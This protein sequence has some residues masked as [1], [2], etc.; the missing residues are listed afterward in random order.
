M[1]RFLAMAPL[2]VAAFVTGCIQ[3]APEEVSQEPADQEIVRKPESAAFF[4]AVV[5]N[6]AEAYRQFLLSYPNGR[7]AGIVQDLLTRCMAAVC[8]NE[9]ELQV[10]LSNALAVSK[11]DQVPVAAVETPPARTEAVAGRPAASR[12]GLN[13]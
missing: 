2:A 10:A 4:D 7:F 1:I 9:H 8:A 5:V 12:V 3:P 6:D 11:A 13:Y